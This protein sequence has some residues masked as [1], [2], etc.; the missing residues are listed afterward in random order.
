PL[1]LSSSPPL[2]LS[3]PLLLSLSITNTPQL[4]AQT[5]RSRLGT[6]PRLCKPSL[7][8]LCVCVCVCGCLC[9]CVCVCVCVSSL[10]ENPIRNHSLDTCQKCLLAGCMLTTH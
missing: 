6:Q 8:G 1:S 2:S 3:L 9:M 4:L 5:L 10:M 7:S